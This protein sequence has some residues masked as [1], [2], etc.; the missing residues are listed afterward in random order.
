M[1]KQAVGTATTQSIVFNS[2]ILTIN[3]KQIADVSDVNITSSFDVKSYRTLNSIKKR[4]L[5]R[6]GL[7]QSVTFT[8]EGGKAREVYSLF[9]SSSSAVASGKDYTVKDGQQ[10]TTTGVWV[11]CYEAD[12][13][14]KAYQYQLNS[15]V[16]GKMDTA[17]STDEFAN[18]SVE[19]MCI[20]FTLYVDDTT[21][22]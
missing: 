1:S 13:T 22:N 11:T 19:I 18:V 10:N 15:P 5:R 4:A 17:L 12:D 6:S 9:Y 14:T 8:I 16:L 7:E 21:S 2:G 20:D 3:G